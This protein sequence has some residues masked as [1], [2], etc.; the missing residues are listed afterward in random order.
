ML[1]RGGMPDIG[2]VSFLGF[3]ATIASVVVISP[4]IEAASCSAHFRGGLD[5]W[6]PAITDGLGRDRPVILFDNA[7]VAGSSGDTPETIHAMGDDAIAFVRAVAFLDHRLNRL[8][9]IDLPHRDREDADSELPLSRIALRL[10]APTTSPPGRVQSILLPGWG[11]RQAT[12]S[13]AVKC[14]RHERAGPA[15][16][17]RHFCGLLP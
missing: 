7:G 13:P 3:S 17:L 1:P 10:N 6:D 16:G 15:G 11:W 4:A 2:S 8:L 14:F 12:R 5:H 9:V